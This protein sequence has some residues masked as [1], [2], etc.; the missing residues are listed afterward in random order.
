[1]KLQRAQMIQEAKEA[2]EKERIEEEQ[3]R[4]EQGIDWGMGESFFI[5]QSIKDSE[6]FVHM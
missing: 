3:K 1:M 5:D 6:D 2:L 4:E